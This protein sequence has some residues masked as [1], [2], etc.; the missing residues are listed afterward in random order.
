MTASII[1]GLILCAK[2]DSQPKQGGA[3]VTIKDK[4]RELATRMQATLKPI[5]HKLLLSA[6]GI[7]YPILKN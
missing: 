4:P 6:T 7:Y 3:M 2:A 1:P 5:S